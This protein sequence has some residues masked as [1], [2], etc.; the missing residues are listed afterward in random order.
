MKIGI[1]IRS[2]TEPTP[3]GVGVY[4]RSLVRSFQNVAPEVELRLFAWGARERSLRDL[5]IAE[6]EGT[7]LTWLRKPSKLLSSRAALWRG[8][9]ADRVVGGVDVWFS[10]NINFTA[11]SPGTPHVLT[12]HDLSFDLYPSFFSLRRRLWHVATHARRMISLATHLVCDSRS[13]AQ[14][15]MARYGIPLERISVVPL[16]APA[17]VRPTAEVRTQ[18][19]RRLK[20]PE[21]YLLAIGTIEPRKNLVTLVQAFE[22]VAWSR[23]ELGLVIVGPWGWRSGDFARAISASPLADHIH[24][25]G[26]LN[27][28]DK[29][30]LLT[31]ALALYSVS[32]YEGFG[33]PVLEAMQLG[34]PVLTA[35][36][37]SLPE[38][39]RSA[40]VLIDPER[41]M[42]ITQALLELLNDGE[43]SSSLARRGYLRS[44]CYSWDECARQTLKV[45]AAVA[46]QGV[47]IAP[48]R[49]VAAEVL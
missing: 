48:E 3:T 16:G 20:L 5:E 17:V 26:Y 15:L 36:I 22:E 41:P 47:G 49:I 35:N 8:V 38:V 7:T 34:V 11:L 2:L 27:E 18:V 43:L 32:S 1:D 42:A 12:V 44:K 24:V 30:A 46:E 23:P 33:L 19:R 29:Q 31:D 28:Q 4:T 39:T 45:L 40:A 37:S 14:D 10:P 9:P 21:Q 25:V 13:T 6:Q